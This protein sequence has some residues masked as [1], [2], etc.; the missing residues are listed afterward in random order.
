MLKKI[1]VIGTSAGGFNALRRL[2]ARLDPGPNAAVL[3]VIHVSPESPGHLAALLGRDCP[4][5][6]KDAADRTIDGGT[7]YVA[8]PERHL[9]VENGGMRLIY[10][11][12][13]NRARPSIDVLFRTAS[14]VYRERTIG[15]ILTGM[16]DDGTAGLF[17]VKRYGGITI[18][19]D[20]RDAEFSSM[21]EHALANV[22]VDYRLSL[23]EIAPLLNR[24]TR[25]ES[26]FPLKV[27]AAYQH[28]N[29]D[30]MMRD[31]DEKSAKPTLYTCPDCHGPLL[32]ISDGS[33]TRF[34]C[35]VGHGY[36]LNSLTFAQSETT[37]Q[38]LWAA[39]QALKTKAELEETQAQSSEGEG[40][41]TSAESFRQHAAETR[42]NIA[43]LEDMISKISG[44]TRS[45]GPGGSSQKQ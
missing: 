16:L 33:P 40:D 32:E 29:G 18:V 5:P 9:I 28:G 11:P 38:A 17:Y 24:L 1:I 42:R 13:E 35:I 14:F 30:K 3:T 10:G 22:Q 8:P 43:I 34:R 12:K 25:E 31:E 39:L 45:N 36:G 19:Q 41:W 4:V 21:P 20:P 2:F 23:D 37:E 15:V 44:K 27:P 6:V 7:I 26:L